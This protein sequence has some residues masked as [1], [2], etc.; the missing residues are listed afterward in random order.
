MHVDTLAGYAVRRETVPAAYSLVIGIKYSYFAKGGCALRAVGCRT[1][2][3]LGLRLPNVPGQFGKPH[4]SQR[5]VL[6][7]NLTGLM[8]DCAWAGCVSCISGIG[9]AFWAARG[10]RLSRLCFAARFG[11]SLWCLQLSQGP[12]RPRKLQA[13][14][15]V[16]AQRNFPKSTSSRPHRSHRRHGRRLV[17]DLRVAPSRLLQPRLPRLRKRPPRNPYLAQ[18]SRIRFPPTFRQPARP[19]SRTQ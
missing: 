13:L 12:L 10:H 5:P 8:G 19:I 9:A 11:L 4:L 6:C 3:R 14:V 1:S 7:H 18:S 15:K 2:F 17:L 16:Q